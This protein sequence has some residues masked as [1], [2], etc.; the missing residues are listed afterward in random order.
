MSDDQTLLQDDDETAVPSPSASTPWSLP[1]YTLEV[2]LGAGAFGEVWA[3]VQQGSGQQ[4]AVKL[5]HHRSFDVSILAREVERLRELGRHPHVVTLLDAR[6][7][8]APRFL[9]MPRLEGSLANCGAA[10]PRQVVE[11]L[12]QAA[13]A[14]EF[15]HR[16]GVLHCDIK[17]ANMLLDSEGR[18]LLCDFGQAISTGEK[19]VTLGSLGYMAPEHINWVLHREG[20]PDISWDVYALGATAYMLLG[21]R[22]PRLNTERLTTATG[23]AAK[24]RLELSAEMLASERL[25]PLR[26]LN[27]HVDR[28]LAAIVE[29]CLSLAPAN[30]M[31]SAGALLEELNRR[32]HR[33]P[34]KSR[35]FNPFY[36]AKRWIRRNRLL[37]SVLV[38]IIGGSICLASWLTDPRIPQEKAFEVPVSSGGINA[39]E[40]AILGQLFR[41]RVNPLAEGLAFSLS[42]FSRSPAI[43]KEALSRVDQADLG[44]LREIRAHAERPLPVEGSPRWHLPSGWHRPSEWDLPENERPVDR[45]PSDLYT[46]GVWNFCALTRSGNYPA[47]LRRHLDLLFMARAY[48][49]IDSRQQEGELLGLW[50][51]YGRTLLTASDA[52]LDEYARGLDSLRPY[53]QPANVHYLAQPTSQ[54]WSIENAMELQRHRLTNAWMKCLKTGDYAALRRDTVDFFRHDLQLLPVLLHPPSYMNF[55]LMRKRAMAFYTEAISTAYWETRFDGLRVEVAAERFRRKKGRWPTSLEELCPDYLAEV[56]PN[57]ITSGKLALDRG[58]VRMT[59]PKRPDDGIDYNRLQMVGSDPFDDLTTMFLDIDSSQVT[60]LVLPPNPETVLRMER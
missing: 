56:P 15:C 19:T 2:Q 28:D 12:K 30:R 22:L 17:P 47:A 49:G 7:A 18:L 46:L 1:G 54:G 26:T 51:L 23:T 57:R 60:I 43:P 32:E 59:L 13:A 36:V 10:A 55:Q 4:V 6:L 33:L 42:S 39:E 50:R 38:A 41:G 27:P 45:G 21:G 29:K 34:V 14:I 11:W 9:V 40:W 37:C 48:F 58:E 31:P 52:A 25:V 35:R 5:F 24:Q 20:T 3:G 8:E 53:N 44:I 16:K